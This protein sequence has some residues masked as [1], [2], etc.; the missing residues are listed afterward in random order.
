LKYIKRYKLIS[1]IDIL[2]NPIELERDINTTM[3]DIL[4]LGFIYSISDSYT[5]LKIKF[6]LLDTKKI[7]LDDIKDTIITFLSYMITKYNIVNKVLI[8]HK[9]GYILISATELD[10]IGD[11][12]DINSIVFQINE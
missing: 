11:I 3:I 2:N 5:L 10:E 8:N 7:S 4:D 6:S 12:N 1:R 9:S